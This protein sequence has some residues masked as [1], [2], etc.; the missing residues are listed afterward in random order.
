LADTPTGWRAYADYLAWQTVEG[1]TGKSKAYSSM[2]KGWALGGA[3]FKK[4][5]LQDHAVAEESRAWESD[6]VREVREL[7]WQA[8]L[9]RLLRETPA[10]EMASH[11]KSA[12]WKVSL[13]LRMKESTDASNGW[14]AERLQMGSAFYL[15]KHV[16]LHLK[17]VKG[18][19]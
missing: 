13:A 3:S 12:P 15:S 4:T 14:L 1:P 7:K 10:K 6:G 17:K 19:A 2:S 8:A 18:K 9:D 5:L 16:G 11:R